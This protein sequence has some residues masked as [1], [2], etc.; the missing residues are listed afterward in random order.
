MPTTAGRHPPPSFTVRNQFTY[1]SYYICLQRVD[2]VVVIDFEHDD[3]RSRSR[4]FF[5]TIVHEKEGGLYNDGNLKYYIIPNEIR[6][7]GPKHNNINCIFYIMTDK[8]LFFTSN[9]KNI[10]FLRLYLK[11]VSCPG[12]AVVVSTLKSMCQ[13]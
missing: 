11:T 1:R 10:T 2:L 12:C 8:Y 3:N 9:C 5:P 13:V 4:D 6:E 7:M